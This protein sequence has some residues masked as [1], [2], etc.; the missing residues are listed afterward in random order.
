VTVLYRMK[1]DTVRPQ[2]ELVER[3]GSL[4]PERLRQVLDGIE[5]LLEPR[6]LP[7]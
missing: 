4:S 5:L 3:I 7:E 6:D 2:D 1:K